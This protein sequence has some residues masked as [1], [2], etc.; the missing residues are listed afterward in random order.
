MNRKPFRYARPY[1]KPFRFG[2][3]RGRRHVPESPTRSD[4]QRNRE[5]IMA[6]AREALAGPDGA[7]MTGIAKLAG[8]G[9]G[10]LYRHFPTRE[11]L[12]MALY[13]HDIQQV[14]DLAPALLREHPPQAALRLWLAEVARYGRLKYG[15]A[16]VIHA[17]TDNGLADPNYAPFVAAIRTLLDAGAAAGVTKPGLD[18]EDVLLQLSVLWRIP[19]TEDAPQRTQRILDLVVDGL[20]TR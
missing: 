17:A 6:A 9:V 7:S 19:P 15:V 8:V 4:A 1:R 12:V 13:S 14:I 5:R 11:A 2:K 3:R 10:T 20:L 18:P 16:E